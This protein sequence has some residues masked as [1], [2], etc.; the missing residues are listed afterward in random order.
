MYM[1]CVI[2]LLIQLD[3]KLQELSEVQKSVVDLRCEM[4]TERSKWLAAKSQL[5]ADVDDALRDR[6]E[7]REKAAQLT[8]EVRRAHLLNQSLCLSLVFVL[9]SST[10]CRC[11]NV[12]LSQWKHSL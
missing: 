8:A 1:G 9:S 6:D 10:L 7:E 2:L 5:Q 4:D 3:Q 12:I 11:L